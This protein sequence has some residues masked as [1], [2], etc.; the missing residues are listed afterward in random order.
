MLRGEG[1]GKRFLY[2]AFDGGEGERGLKFL[3]G[4]KVT[5]MVGQYGCMKLGWAA[6]AFLCHA[7]PRVWTRT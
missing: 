5:W 3:S 1:R 4:G 6:I 7:G 2:H